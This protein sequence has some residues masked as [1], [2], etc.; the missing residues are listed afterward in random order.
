ME[1]QLKSPW[2]SFH[3]GYMYIVWLKKCA[4]PALCICIMSQSPW[5][6]KTDCP[7]QYSLANACQCLSPLLEEGMLFELSPVYS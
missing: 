1:Q 6:Q 4:S 7:S 3:P 2:S 5:L